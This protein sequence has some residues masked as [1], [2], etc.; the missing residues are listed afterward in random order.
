MRLVQNHRCGS[1]VNLAALDPHQSILH[2]ID[3][4]HSML[5]SQRIQL[6]DQHRTVHR[7]TVQLRRTPLIELDLHIQRLVRCGQRIDRPLIRLRRR[8]DPRIL[9]HTRLDRTPPQVLID[10]EN[11]LLRRLH[12]DS[13]LRGVIDLLAP[14]PAPFPDR[15][16]HLQVRSQRLH[17]HVEPHLIVPFAGAAMRHSHRTA[18]LGHFHHPQRNQRSSQRRCQRILPFVQGSRHQRRP[19][20]VIDEHIPA[21]LDHRI[22]RPRLQSLRLDRLQ[23]SSLPQ[24]ARVRHHVQVVLLSNPLDRD[25]SIQTT[26]VRQNDFIPCHDVNS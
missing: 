15:G 3:P 25:G 21:I 13:V 11:A 5:S 22:D 26:A 10:A 18:F 17:R 8:S 23:F 6:L 16:D 24:I 4:P 1:L 20:E 2:V 19:D 7:L 9:E 12:F 14:R